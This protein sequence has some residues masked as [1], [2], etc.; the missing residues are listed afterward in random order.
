MREPAHQH[1][2]QVVYVAILGVAAAVALGG[3]AFA[4]ALA[5]GS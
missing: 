4:A 1:T 5:G 2:V 3:G